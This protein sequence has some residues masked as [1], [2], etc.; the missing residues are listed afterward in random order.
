MTLGGGRIGKANKFFWGKRILEI[1]ER[2]GCKS[3][4]C[5]IGG[6]LVFK[7]GSETWRVSDLAQ[8]LS[9]KREEIGNC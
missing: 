2:G 4:P 6:P 3:R 5:T 7:K 8:V 1:R 9:E